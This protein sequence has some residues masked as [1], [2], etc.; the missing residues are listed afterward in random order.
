MARQPSLLRDYDTRDEDECKESFEE[1]QEAIRAIFNEDVA[2]HVIAKYSADDVIALNE[3]FNDWTDA[4]C[5]DG[6][7]CD[8]LYNNIT[9]TDD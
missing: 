4:L 5:K 1:I 8:Y 3:A 9:R 7:I 6:Q 2:P